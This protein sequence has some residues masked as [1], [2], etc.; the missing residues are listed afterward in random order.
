[1]QRTISTSFS[2]AYRFAV[3]NFL[4]C[5]IGNH[6]IFHRFICNTEKKRKRFS[7]TK[8]ATKSERAVFSPTDDIFQ[9]LNFKLVSSLRVNMPNV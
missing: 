7:K 9:D 6:A 8:F 1:M 5:F 4:K 2:S 3:A